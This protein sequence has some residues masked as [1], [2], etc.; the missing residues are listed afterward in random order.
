MIIDIEYLQSISK[1]ELTKDEKE[2]FKTE[3]FNAVEFVSGISDIE[4]LEE[5]TMK[6][7]VS[8]SMLRDDETVEKF[9]REDILLNAPEQKDG[10]FVTPLVVE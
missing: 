8:I 9:S 10:C 3:L 4:N 2:S 7:A 5:I 6:N 1:I